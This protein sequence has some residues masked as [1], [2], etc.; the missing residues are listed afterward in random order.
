[1]EGWLRPP[2]LRQLKGRMNAKMREM[3]L[4]EV[5]EEV[6]GKQSGVESR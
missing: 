6:L 3:M 1:M 5:A 4:K 2:V